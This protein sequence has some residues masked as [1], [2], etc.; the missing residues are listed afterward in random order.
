MLRTAI[1]GL[2]SWGQVLVDAI[3]VNGR[4]KG[5]LICFT[6]AVTRT[7]AR[8]QSFAAQQGLTLSSNLDD[9][10]GDNVDA[11]VLAS[12]NSAHVDQIVAAASAGKTGL[13]RKAARLFIHRSSAR[14][15]GLRGRGCCLG[16][17]S[18]PALPC[19]NAKN[20]VVA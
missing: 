6:H 16:T 10:L 18:Q 9:V 20:E 19:G 11:I 8:A 5:D 17:G 14:G 1:V 12:I 15:T 13:C 2:G 3:Q 4:A 7:P